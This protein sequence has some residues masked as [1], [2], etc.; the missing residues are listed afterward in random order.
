MFQERPHA[1]HCRFKNKQGHGQHARNSLQDR[2]PGRGSACLPMGRLSLRISLSQ[3]ALSERGK[4]FGS[5]A[6][7]GLAGWAHCQ[8]AGGARLG[9][10]SPSSWCRGTQAQLSSLS[11]LPW[12]L[13]PVPS[14]SKAIPPHTDDARPPLA[15]AEAIL[16]PKRDPTGGA[17]RP[18]Q[19][20]P[21]PLL[22]GPVPQVSRFSSQA[23]ARGLFEPHCCWKATPR[24]QPPPAP[25]GT[26]RSSGPL[27]AW[28]CYLR[29]LRQQ[30]P[31]TAWV[32]KA[33]GL[34]A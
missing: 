30:N 1:A 25:P 12:G 34:P 27:E 29:W 33:L 20:H 3:P 8:R 23:T 24:A 15:Q 19:A 21:P 16:C 32:G 26:P 14:H 28:L 4:Q 2:W 10:T 31:W 13:S 17:P 7:T 6:G 22:P 11:T 18:V 9:R 5:P